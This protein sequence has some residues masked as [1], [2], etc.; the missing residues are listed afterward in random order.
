MD[1]TLGNDP[2][3]DSFQDFLFIYV[4]RTNQKITPFDIHKNKTRKTQTH[5]YISE[6]NIKKLLENWFSES[7]LTDS[8]I[9]AVNHLH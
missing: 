8:S 2:R 1:Y 6:K 7:H 9:H 4:C 5:T 3:I